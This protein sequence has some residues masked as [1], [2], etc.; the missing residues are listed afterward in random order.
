M[1]K[2][3][4]V[5][6]TEKY[7][8][9]CGMIEPGDVVIAGVSGGADSI[10]LL[11]VLCALREKMGFQV[12]VC[13]VNHGIRGE[14]AEADEAYVKELCRRLGAEARFFHEN[15]ELIARKRKQSSEE[16]GREV[17]R[18]AFARMCE[19]DGGTKIATAHH[20]DD[21]AET[22]LLNL[23]RGT[24]FKG[25][26]GIWPVRG[27]WIRP[28][29]YLNREQ[30]ESWLC[31]QGIAWRTDETN[32]E[33]AYTRNR[34]RHHI[35]PMLADQVNP[36]VVSH[37][38]ELSIQ[39]R[40]ALEYLEQGTDQAWDR[41]VSKADPDRILLDRTALAREPKVLQRQL[42]KR[43]ISTVRGT[44]KDIASVHIAAVLELAKSRT[45]KRV[46]L[47]GH[48]AAQNE[49]AG[50]EI[51]RES[52]EKNGQKIEGM[53]EIMLN[54]PG[55]TKVPGQNL[56]ISCRLLEGHCAKEAEEIPQ[57]SYTKW[58][59][60]DIIEHG[61]S[62]RTRRC[63]DYLTVD[64]KGSR[65]KLKFYFINEK[66]PREERE[67]MP[68]I[69]DGHEIVWI[70]G[71]RMSQ[72]YYVSSDTEKILEIKI[73]EEKENVRDNQGAGSGREG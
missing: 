41:C 66:I 56:V 42:V 13:H 72:A 33:D 65:Q 20:Q 9:T 5:E 14:E 36:K 48:V 19:E 73:T 52:G 21:N 45:G 12:K 67:K 28:L 54:I 50:I 2:Q 32:E 11:F 30:T 31:E 35:L 64:D 51:L 59:D 8:R 71:Y 26:C 3:N 63:G 55:E 69:A 15:V 37:L 44:E 27:R 70:P 18:A 40:E 43:C 24:G 53:K 1:M 46:D 23:S 60:Y 16:A 38:E 7:I 22:V 34:I 58:M 68:L 49:Y 25:L 39:A 47:P 4:L 29:L 6:L 62:V 57:K 17:R 61:L 10:C